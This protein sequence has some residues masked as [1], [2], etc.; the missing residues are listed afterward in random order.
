MSAMEHR[1]ADIQTGME[2]K[3]CHRREINFPSNRLISF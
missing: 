1:Q 2:R 3:V